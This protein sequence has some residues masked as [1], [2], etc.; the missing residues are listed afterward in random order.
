M[1]R[2]GFLVLQKVVFF[3]DCPSQSPDLNIGQPVWVDT[4]GSS[5]RSSQTASVPAEMFDAAHEWN[6]EFL[7]A[8][9]L[10]TQQHLTFLS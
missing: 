2:I 9:S 5:T 6:V 4:R 1:S 10:L 8:T 3:Q 7:H